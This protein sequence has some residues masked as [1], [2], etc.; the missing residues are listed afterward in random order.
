MRS[1]I[2]H[3]CSRKLCHF[4][5]S[6]AETS[7]PSLASKFGNEFQMRKRDQISIT[8]IKEDSK[9]QGAALQAVSNRTNLFQVGFIQS[10]NRN[11][12]TRGESHMSEVVLS[13]S[14]QIGLIDLID[15]R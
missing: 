12:V 5:P 1:R 3:M 2:S 13:S 14:E 11:W 4:H 6:F 9:E 7:L 10:R 15:L 8:Q